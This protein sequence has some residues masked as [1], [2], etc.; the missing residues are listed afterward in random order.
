MLRALLIVDIQKDY[1]P[2]GRMELVGAEAAAGRAAELLSAFRE[3]GEPVFHIQHVWDAPD[4]PFFAPGT[5][6]VEIHPAVTP[7]AGEPLITKEHA[8]AFLDTSLEADLRG[9]GVEDV[10][11]CGMMTSMC[12][13]AS[14]RASDDLGFN[15][16]IAA[17][18][19]A[20]PDLKSGDETI[21]GATVHKAVLAALDAMVAEVRDTSEIIATRRGSGAVQAGRAD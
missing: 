4:A 11:I 6:G 20:A 5:E 13:D 10:V 21:P 18:A 3:S 16:S 8:N 1:F 12:V 7:A 17:D 15:T 9:A 14:A 19:C 2:G